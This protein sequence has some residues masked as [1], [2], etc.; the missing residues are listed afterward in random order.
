MGN[1]AIEIKTQEDKIKYR[2]LCEKHYE[3]CQRPSGYE[4]QNKWKLSFD[5]IK[6]YYYDQQGVWDYF[7]TDKEE[8]SQIENQEKY[9]NVLKMALEEAKKTG[10]DHEKDAINST[11][12]AFEASFTYAC[13]RL[14]AEESMC[15]CIQNKRYANYK[16]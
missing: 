9:E 7:R 11:K 5:I 12:L 6:E 10:G 1:K 2:Y 14:C 3:A 16:Y 15:T 4:K 13:C 8:M